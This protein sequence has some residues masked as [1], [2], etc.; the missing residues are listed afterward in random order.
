MLRFESRER[1]IG[2]RVDSKNS[3]KFIS[4]LQIKK[5][6]VI[7]HIIGKAKALHCDFL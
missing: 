4:F 6:F 1:R 7:L 5:T 2:D 3:K